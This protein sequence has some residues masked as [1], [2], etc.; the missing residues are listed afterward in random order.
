MDET[1]IPSEP[2]YRME[3]FE[4]QRL[5]VLP[6]PQVETALGAAGTRRLLVT[7]AGYFPKARGHLRVRPRGCPETVVLLCVA[8]RGTVTIA[9]E[10]HP[11]T[12]STSIAI[13]AGA[14]H[15]YEASEEDPWTIWWVHVRG[16]DAAELTAQ[17]LGR[18]S[19]VTRL[20]AMDRVVALF[21]ELVSTL[22]RRLSPPQLLMASGIAWNLLT[23]IAADSIL[24]SEG[25]ALERAMRYLEARVDGNIQVSELAALVDMSPSHLSAL[26]R[27]ATGSGPATFHTSLRM[28][29]ARNLLDTT[30]L[31]VREIAAA[32]GYADPLYFSR[33]FRRLHGLNPTSYRAQ[34]KG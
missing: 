31:S 34:H 19:P 12:A 27:Q 25:S 22:E 5:C 30:S 24:P 11:L 7:D 8:G 26:F 10:V 17:T 18:Q 28:S 14:P 23:R 1:P 6:R 13:A 29:H 21:D 32:V 3:G 15:V 4:H 20:R 33:H 9:G 16:T 2:H